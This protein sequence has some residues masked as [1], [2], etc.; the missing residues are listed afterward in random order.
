MTPTALLVTTLLLAH[1]RAGESHFSV[2]PVPECAG[3]VACEG[4]RWSSFYE[5]WV[6]Q[7]SIAT[8]KARYAVIG[9]A[10]SHEVTRALCRDS[11]ERPVDGCTPLPGA[12]RWMWADLA[13]FTSAIAIMESGLREDVQVGRGRAGKPDD[14]GGQGRGPANE[15]CA[16]QI[17]PREIDS[18]ALL[19]TDLEANRRCFRAGIQRIVHARR[20]CAWRAPKVDWMFATASLYGTGTSC[21]SSNEG[22]TGKRAGF[23]R[24]MIARFW[25]ARS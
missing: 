19:G 21:V 25:G 2:E 17:H 23:A 7:E 22:K 11:Q 1:S 9:E 14:A 15:R 3:A 20:W 13:G 5:T 12:K 4:A 24:D 16:M 18:D 6:R 8:A 10:M